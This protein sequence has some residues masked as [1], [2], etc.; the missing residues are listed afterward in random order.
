MPYIADPLYIRSTSL[1]DFSPAIRQTVSRHKIIGHAEAAR[2]NSSRSWSNGV[3][4]ASRGR[5]DDSQR[6]AAP[7]T[8]DE[9]GVPTEGSVWSHMRTNYPHLPRCWLTSHQSGLESSLHQATVPN[10]WTNYTWFNNYYLRRIRR[11]IGNTKSGGCIRLLQIYF[12]II[13]MNPLLLVYPLFPRY[14]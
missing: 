2:T 9:Q 11:H 3:E 6:E 10:T 5:N 14:I 12:S 8:A 7:S 1:H 4:A 13:W